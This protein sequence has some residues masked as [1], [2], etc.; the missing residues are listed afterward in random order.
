M[1]MSQIEVRNA[2]LG[3]I[4][5][6][7]PDAAKQSDPDWFKVVIEDEDQAM[8]LYTSCRDLP[9]GLFRAPSGSMVV[10]FYSSEKDVPARLASESIECQGVYCGPT[11][12][13]ECLMSGHERLLISD[14]L[15]KIILGMN[16]GRS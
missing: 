16:R 5:A 13:V 7:Y 11:L 10:M 15:A 1:K 9:A 3:A 8:R 14:K 4:D 2:L 12:L 6:A